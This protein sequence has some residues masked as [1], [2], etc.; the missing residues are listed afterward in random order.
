MPLA[1]SRPHGQEL[2]RVRLS[3]NCNKQVCRILKRARESAGFSTL[4]A[5]GLFTKAGLK[6]R[7]LEEGCGVP[8]PLV[9][10]QASRA[11]GEGGDGAW[12]SARCPLL[13][14]SQGAAGRDFLAQG[15]ALESPVCFHEVYGASAFLGCVS[16]RAGLCW[17][18]DAPALL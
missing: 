15:S 6:K 11:H 4:L 3:V 14:C 7:S 9:G 17:S 18:P 1:Q 5:D 8:N 16:L 12:A 2:L 13:Q 10:A